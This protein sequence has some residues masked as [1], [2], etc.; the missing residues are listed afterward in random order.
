MNIF[1][2]LDIKFPSTWLDINYQI[3]FFILVFICSQIFHLRNEN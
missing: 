2:T 1:L 3:F